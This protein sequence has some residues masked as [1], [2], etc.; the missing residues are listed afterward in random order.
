VSFRFPCAAC[1]VGQIIRYI[2]QRNQWNN[3]HQGGKQ[4]LGGFCCSS[5]KTA[6]EEHDLLLLGATKVSQLEEQRELQ[7]CA[8]FLIAMQLLDLHF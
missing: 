1:K 6:F 7:Q 8:P 5:V 3:I 4:L 2:R